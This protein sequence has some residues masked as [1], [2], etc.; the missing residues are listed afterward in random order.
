MFDTLGSLGTVDDSVLIDTIVQ[1]ARAEAQA[2]SARFTV[3]AELAMRRLD[4][5]DGRELWACDGWD[6]VAA[7]IGA[8]LS[9]GSREASSQMSMALA[10]R[11]RLPKVAALFASG[12]I[13]AKI[14][15]QICWRTRLVNDTDRAA[16]LDT[17]L[18]G[19]LG[20]WGPLSAKK[21]HAVIDSWVQKVDPAAVI[22]TG[23]AARARTIRLGK[24]DDDSGITSIWGA[25]LTTDAALLD[26]ALTALANT[27]CPDDPR[28][29]GQRRSDAL[30]VLAVRGDRLACLCANPD[31]SAAGV[32]ARAA[33]VII[34][35]LTDTTPPAAA[36]PQLHTP[37]PV[38]VP[39]AGTAQPATDTEDGPEAEPDAEPDAE[40]E[41]EPDAEPAAEPEPALDPAAH[42]DTERQARTPDVA[43]EPAAET[44]A[45]VQPAPAPV[46]A[47]PIGYLPGGQ[48]IPAPLLADLA[49][50]GAT[51][52]PLTPASA[53][54]TTNN[55]RPTK[56]LDE[57]V[58]L[59]A[60][61]CTFP[62]CDTPAMAC[63]LD[64]VTAWPTGPTHGA[65]LGPKCR[66][67]HLLK[68]FWTG[69]AG[70]RDRQEPD[71][72]TIWTS[73][74]GHTYRNVPLTQIL[75]PDK[76]LATPPPEST[77]NDQKK[78][79]NPGRTLMMPTRRRTRTTDRTNRITYERKL[80]EQ[81]L[82]AITHGEKPTP[83][84]TPGTRHRPTWDSIF[85]TNHPPDSQP[86]P[87]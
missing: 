58:R 24:P 2:A 8:A 82:A 78:T 61:T 62:G 25:L 18:A 30:G 85:T 1:A 59:R 39:P 72:T 14:V 86:P 27:V 50:R 19:S 77:T 69:P 84:T 68:T 37:P 75:F 28:T 6:A 4:D 32:D 16:L 49:A 74:T 52:R 22:A 12:A 38:P 17:A 33:A 44:G 47:G 56:A 15:A 65:N 36:D 35:V 76:N 26:Q 87:F 57:F 46:P 64:H 54:G 83:P 9:I 55:Y 7:E 70:W 29:I 10:L 21:L 48:I 43:E 20:D 31:C 42:T 81:H 5:Q 60:M 41:A 40:A 3:I 80:N 71:G 23:Y 45:T 53:L 73:P 79:Q 51:I 67:H 63:D 34:H 11:H 13:S 66:K